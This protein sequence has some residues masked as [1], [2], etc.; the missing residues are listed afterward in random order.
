MHSAEVAGFVSD[1][2]ANLGSICGMAF[3]TS[4]ELTN[5]LTPVL[6]PHGVDIDSIKVHKAGKKSRVLVLIDAERDVDLDT[7]EVLTNEVSQA[8]DD[9]EEQGKV[10]FGAGYTLEVSTR[11]IDAPLVL[12]RHWQKNRGRLVRLSPQDTP[13]RLGALDAAQQQAIVIQRAKRQCLVE[14]VELAQYPHAMVE[15]EFS[16]P[17]Q[18]ELELSNLT[19]DEA[20]QWREEHK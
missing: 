3:P 17:P 4:E 10:Q 1:I 18:S 13:V 6:A 11:G 8:L 16:T 14:V 9:A 15:I 20:M 19:F 5:L 7:L 2:L 12:P